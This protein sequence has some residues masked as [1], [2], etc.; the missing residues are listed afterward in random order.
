MFIGHLLVIV[1]YRKFLLHTLC[2]QSKRKKNSGTKICKKSAQGTQYL[3]KGGKIIT[4]ARNI[5]KVYTDGRNRKPTE[6]AQTEKVR[7]ESI[8]KRDYRVRRPTGCADGAERGWVLVTHGIN[9]RPSCMGEIEDVFLRQGYGV[10]R[11]VLP[12]HEECTVKAKCAA[13]AS[14][15]FPAP[16]FAGPGNPLF[17]CVHCGERSIAPEWP[18]VSAESWLD[19]VRRCREEGMRLCGDRPL[20]YCGFSLGGL[21]GAAEYTQAISPAANFADAPPAAYRG[22][23]LIAPAICLRPWAHLIRLLFPFPGLRL[24]SLAGKHYEVRPY[25]SVAA[26]R[27]L[28]ESRH[29]LR[30]L[31]KQGAQGAKRNAPAP[32]STSAAPAP[33]ARSFPV[34]LIE[35]RFDVLT[36]GR[37]LLRRLKKCAFLSI[38]HHRVKANNLWHH[39]ITDRRAL[40]DAGWQRLEEE[41]RAF[42]KECEEA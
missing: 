39:L 32:V 17:S 35:D 26:Y 28:F 12:G 15:R 41:I 30:R 1:T 24:K 10:L 6:K 16:R 4:K 13:E 7:G 34:L 36:A 20:Y 31:W 3:W 40:G 21:A 38:R 42:M 18:D 23:I 8:M 29:T 27:A 2:R 5:V 22:A 25:T 37:A 9:M 14:G 11:V 33:A 19:A